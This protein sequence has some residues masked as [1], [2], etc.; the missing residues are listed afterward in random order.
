MARANPAR[1]PYAATR[2]LL[3]NLRD[4]R[5]LRRNPLARAEFARRVESDA[6]RAIATRVDS[7]LR[8]VRSARQVAI[9]LRVDTERHDPQSVAT[10]LAL[11][12]RAFYRERRLAH[13]A[14]HAGYLATGRAAAAIE[15]D[16]AARL[17]SRATSLADSGETASAKAIFHDVLAS[18]QPAGTACEALVRLA[19]TEAWLHR[20][21]CARA[22]LDACAALLSHGSLDQARR[23]ALS[24]AVA[25]ARSTV[26][27]FDEGPQAALRSSRNDLLLAPGDR[28]TLA[29][30][31]AALRIGESP[32]A[33]DLLREL[34]SRRRDELPPEFEVDLLTARAEFANFAYS[35]ASLG[36]DLFGRAALLAGV[37]GLRGR[38]LYA[39]HQLSVARWMRSRRPEDRRAYRRLADAVD[40]SL[41]ARLRSILALVAADVEVAI[42]RP[43]RG[44]AAANAVALVST[45][46]YETV[47]ARALAAAALLRMGRLDEAA[48]EAVVATG[49]ARA[50]GHARVLSL[51]QRIC[52]QAYFIKGDRREARSAIEESLECARHFSSPYVQAQAQAIRG[53]IAGRS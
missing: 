4:G 3:R 47:S 40:R 39:L 26:V 16:F 8:A 25:A 33:S 20:F 49:A 17:L 14:F 28:T 48:A 51:A 9:L 30:A 52:A 18:G 35:D 38:E 19:T 7:A 32:L 24:D 5:E 1:S 46:R 2:H 31:L 53:R 43:E 22:H 45:N 27:M 50:Q 11:S 44:L 13:D 37:H 41:P 12:M 21:D 42:G 29:R 34:T 6:L 36:E 15:S 10:D 23:A